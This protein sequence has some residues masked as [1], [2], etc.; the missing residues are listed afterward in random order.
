MGNRPRRDR[1]IWLLRNKGGRPASDALYSNDQR[2]LDARR[3]DTSSASLRRESFL[4]L[5]PFSLQSSDVRLRL[6]GERV[7]PTVTVHNDNRPDTTFFRLS[8]ERVRV[9]ILSSRKRRSA[10]YL[11]RRNEPPMA[12]WRRRDDD[13][14]PGGIASRRRRK[15]VHRLT[16]STPLTENAIASLSTERSS[17]RRP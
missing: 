15:P 10:P 12:P 7:E 16:S 14:Q 4:L 8:G 9:S 3:R 11:S 6:V 5:L 17:A 2:I 13:Y 1:S